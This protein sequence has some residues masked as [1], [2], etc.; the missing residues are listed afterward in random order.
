[1][2]N[3][4]GAT[5]IN[6]GVIVDVETQSSGVAIPGGSRVIAMIGQG[7]TGETIVSQ[8]LGGGD[9][10]LDPTF[11]TNTGSDGR[12]FA[13][14][15]YPLISNRTTIFRN[16]IPLNLLELGPI[17]ASTVV[18]SV[19]D[20]QLDPT[21]GHLLMQSAH[22]V[23]QGGTFFTPLTTNVGVGYLN[24]LTLVDVNDPPETWTIR[25]VSVQRNSMS[26]P[27]LGTAKFEAFGT[28]SGS[29][30][31]ANGNSIIWMAGG[32]G[33]VVSNGILSFSI[34]ET[35]AFVPGDAFTVIVASGVLVRGDSL[36]STEIPQNNINNPTLTQ[37]MSDV[38]A[39]SGNP[40]TTNNLSLG[41]QLCYANGASSMIALQAA[42]PLP[43]RSSYVLDTSVNALSTNP[44][45]FIFPLPLGVVPDF[46]SDIHFFVTNPVT[47]VETQV[48]PNQL[49][50]AEGT[51]AY[52][53][54]GGSVSQETD[55]TISGSPTE[56]E[57]IFSNINFPAGYSY[58]YTVISSWD[59][60]IT[61]FDGE[62]VPR[63]GDA[64]VGPTIINNALFSS[65]SVTFTSNYF[66]KL[67]KVI[68]AN[69]TSNIGI[70]KITGVSN[71]Q[72]AISTII[73]GKV[74]V[75]PVPQNFVNGFP[76]FSGPGATPGPNGTTIPADPHASGSEA[77]QIISLVT[78]LPVD[79]Y[80]GTDG[81]L[82]P[83]CPFGVSDGYSCGVGLN[84]GTATFHSTAVDF[85]NLDP[86]IGTDGYY[87]LKINNVS[88]TE[89]LPNNGIFEIIGYDSGTNT[90]TIARRFV[91]EAN[92]RYE[93]LDPNQLSTY[94]VVNHN[95]VP[96]GNQLR[97]TIVDARDAIFYDEGWLNALAALETVEC[98]IVV[99]L[100]N[101]TISAIFQNAL[102]HCI[103]MSNLVNRKERVLFIGAING[104]TPANLTGAKLAAVEDLGIFE[105]VPN[106]DIT[107]TL[108]GNIQDIANYSVPD[109]YGFTY[110]C[111]YFY[112][113]QIVVQAGANNVLIDGFYIAAAAA[114]YA[115]ADLALENPFTNKVFSG[116]T[117]LSNRTFSS[118]VLQQLSAAGVTTLNPVSGG[119]RVVWGITTSQ[120][121]FPE[122][123]E[124]SIVF[125]RDRVAKILRS[126]FQGFV[127][128]P[129][130]TNTATALS[131]EA[132]I[133][134][135]SLIT[136]GL[137]TAFSGLTVKQDQVDPRQW[138]IAVN[139]SPTYPI[140]WIYIKVTVGNLGA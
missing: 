37:G 16:G 31:D 29:P 120:S 78:G 116:F 98:D 95:V 40:S 109:A 19:Y 25:C 132:T 84:P 139:I 81:T 46:Y 43:R 127:G 121:G 11:T 73:K 119:G 49:L 76:D 8:A 36:T 47:Q 118:L 66:G 129:Q 128:T 97:V 10:G 137:I 6:P 61:G 99:P 138:D 15:N 21:T 33:D 90:L 2:P 94:V 65:Q 12:H 34:V 71:G 140:N 68:D 79:G 122:E 50:T 113:D 100:P 23:D 9:D 72:L 67:L 93:I 112:P 107:S 7:T 88:G 17:T 13:L 45:D 130:T 80:V 53:T 133:L 74:P 48:L 39:L 26:Q 85:A 38:V 14:A 42:P 22:L 56:E 64:N 108:S 123:Q 1:M 134:L 124:I 69:N 89:V 125:I 101:Q 58:G 87:A 4:P 96:N 115:N 77:F 117:I 41:A 62:I 110:R 18:P 20:A 83:L 70:F 59:D 44:D 126:G 91:T 57:F 24:L 32:G 135:N 27:I 136:Q 3:I 5:N 105:G 55:E 28:V 114:G 52:Y 30:L 35:T 82:T 106:N 111:V 54:L 75:E 102:S 86:S 92:L 63:L 131:T 60:L 51:N 104:L 103:T